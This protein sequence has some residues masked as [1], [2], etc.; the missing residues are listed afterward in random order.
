MVMPAITEP[1]TT[2][3]QLHALPEDGLRHELL[4]GVHVVTPA[5]QV[6]HQLIVLGLIRA[7][8]AVLIRRDDLQLFT[9]PADVVLTPRTLVQPDVLIVRKTPGQPIRAWSEM[10]IPLLAIEI[11]SPSTASRDRGVKRRI[12][13]TSGVGEYW[14]VDLDARLIE[15]WTPRDQRPEVLAETLAWTLPGGASGIIDVEALFTSLDR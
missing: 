12:Y 9:S 6:P 13:Q 5:P 14:I 1:V 7:L 4:D 10:G 3:E 2:I 11:L 8:D 15:R